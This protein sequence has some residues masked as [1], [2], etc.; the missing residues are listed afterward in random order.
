M[1]RLLFMVSF[2]AVCCSICL[3]LFKTIIKPFGRNK[4][5]EGFDMLKNLGK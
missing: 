3:K 1:W 5:G 4:V 2:L